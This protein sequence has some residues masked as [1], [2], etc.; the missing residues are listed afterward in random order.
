MLFSGQSRQIGLSSTA[1]FFFAVSSFSTPDKEAAGESGGECSFPGRDVW[2]GEAALLELI[3][4]DLLGP[5][6]H[7]ALRTRASD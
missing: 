2:A 6:K 5:P 1:I 4:V 7:A 3:D